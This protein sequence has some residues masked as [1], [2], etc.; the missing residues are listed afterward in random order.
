MVLARSSASTVQLN[1]FNDLARKEIKKIGIGN[2]SLNTQG[3]MQ[4][5]IETLRRLGNNKG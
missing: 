4:A 5:G 3:C 1:S 2:H